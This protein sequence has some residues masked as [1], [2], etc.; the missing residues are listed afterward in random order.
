MPAAQSLVEAK[1]SQAAQP[2]PPKMS[3]GNTL[4]RQ[5]C[6]DVPKELDFRPLR[7]GDIAAFFAPR[8][9]AN[10]TFADKVTTYDAAGA[11]EPTHAAANHQQPTHHAAGAQEPTHPTSDQEPTEPAAPTAL[12]K[13][14]EDTVKTDKTRQVATPSRSPTLPAAL[15][16]SPNTSNGSVSSP[17]STGPAS[18]SE[19]AAT[20]TP[21]KKEETK[22]GPAK[23][24]LPAME[25]TT[26]PAPST[27]AS[28]SAKAPATAVVA[29]PNAPAQNPNALASSLLNNVSVAEGVT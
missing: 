19:L 8:T 28:A 6:E 24:E 18:S 2:P 14:P 20:P 23:A 17:A 7:K 5:W 1:S 22:D 11:Q 3:A 9:S 21:C 4:F 16:V 13:L 15:N 26:R 27:P 12:V 29:R 25:N 10:V